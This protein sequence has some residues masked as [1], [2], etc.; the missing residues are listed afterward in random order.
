MERP[1]VASELALGSAVG[2]GAVMGSAS[3]GCIV[4]SGVDFL[5]YPFFSVVFGDRPSFGTIIA[6]TWFFGLLVGANASSAGMAILYSAS[7][8]YKVLVWLVSGFVVSA[9]FL[10]PAQNIAHFCFY[11]I[12][13]CS[14]PWIVAMTCESVCKQGPQRGP[15]ENGAGESKWSDGCR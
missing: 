1:I 4:S 14:S 7:S 15:F 3:Y 8:P 2:I 9:M 11:W 13:V 6:P 12:S 10:F 5:V